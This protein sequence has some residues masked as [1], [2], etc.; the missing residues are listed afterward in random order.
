MTSAAAAFRRQGGRTAC[1]LLHGFTATP[2]EMRFLGN[3]L[4]EQG[5][6]VLAPCIAAHG[7]TPEDLARSS[8]Q[9]WYDSAE[10]A[11]RELHRDADQLVLVGQS[12]GALLAL[13]LATEHPQRVGRLALLAPAIRLSR[14][15]LPWVRPLL[16]LLARWRPYQEKADSGD[17]ADEAA[18]AVRL[19]Y[20]QIP[21]RALHQLLLLQRE[22]VSRLGRVRQPCL[23]VQSRQDHTCAAS[24]VAVLQRRL[25]GP[26]QVRML[27]H[28][29]HVV[30]VDVDRQQVAEEVAQ[31]AA[32]SSA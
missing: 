9:E 20:R 8:W 12:M 2:E 16:P 10:T 31:F 7:T 22:V 23:V 32:A 6:T 11:M 29:F 27:D 5:F 26:V 17:I 14:W 24:G 13:R 25:A 3:H 15:W 18:R 28:S 30:S 19:G 21:V 1:L 4:H